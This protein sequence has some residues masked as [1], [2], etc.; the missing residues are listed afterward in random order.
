MFCRFT[1]TSGLIL[2]NILIAAPSAW[3]E[4][5]EVQIQFSGVVPERTSVSISPTP[6]VPAS[7]KIAKPLAGEK[8]TTLHFNSTQSASVAVSDPEFVSGS[9]P[10]PQ[11]TTRTS[12]LK[13]SSDSNS[14]VDRTFVTIP[15]GQVDLQL[16]TL[17]KTPKNLAP[18]IYNYKTTLTIV[19]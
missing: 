4:S 13:L 3:A 8:F 16:Q 19:P 9:H 17:I 14:S 15:A 2:T 11:G 7:L 10:E 12:L 1:I 6:G 5:T 18:G